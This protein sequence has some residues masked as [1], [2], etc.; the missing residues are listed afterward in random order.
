MHRRM[1]EE[2]GRGGGACGSKAQKEKKEAGS[3]LQKKDTRS[4]RTLQSR[5]SVEKIGQRCQS[6]KDWNR[7][8]DGE[9]RNA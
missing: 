2:Q 3:F 5:S 1:R 4:D 9:K 8:S 6:G 7:N